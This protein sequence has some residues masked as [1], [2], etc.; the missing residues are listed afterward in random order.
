MR[1]KPCRLAAAVALDTG[2]IIKKLEEKISNKMVCK[3]LII[4]NSNRQKS[5]CKVQH[6]KVAFF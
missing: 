6:E 2:E 5:R 1:P 3:T 4:R